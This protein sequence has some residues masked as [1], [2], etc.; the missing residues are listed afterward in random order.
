MMNMTIRC[1]ASYWDNLGPHT[2]IVKF[3]DSVVYFCYILLSQSCH[4]GQSQD[5][6]QIVHI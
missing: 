2:Q 5:R 6:L 3:L 1:L 4:S